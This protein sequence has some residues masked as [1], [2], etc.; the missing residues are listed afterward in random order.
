MCVCVC[1]R[2]VPYLRGE[3]QIAPSGGRRKLRMLWGKRKLD[4]VEAA[5]N[6]R[7]DEIRVCA[8]AVSPNF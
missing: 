3:T 1:V 6:H 8:L 4:P 7:F 5:G 2:P